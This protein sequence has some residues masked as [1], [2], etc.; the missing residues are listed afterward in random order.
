VECC[1]RAGRLVVGEPVGR[2][3]TS[4]VVRCRHADHGPAVPKVTSDTELRGGG[5]NGASELEAHRAGAAGVVA[6]TPP[7]ARSCWKRFRTSFRSRISPCQ[8]IWTRSRTSSA[9]L[10]GAAHRPSGKESIRLRHGHRG[11]ALTRAVPVERVPVERLQRGQELAREL[12]ADIGAPV[13]CTAICIPEPCSTAARLAVWLRSIPV[14]VRERPPS[15]PS[16]GCSG[17]RMARA[18]W[19]PA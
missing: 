16:I 11:Q 5:G 9:R 2:G 14:P 6:T 13:L 15:M 8:S 7:W 19:V 1:R 17:R 10:M 4:L 12:V 3:N 18:R